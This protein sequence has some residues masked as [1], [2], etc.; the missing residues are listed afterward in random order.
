MQGEWTPISAGGIIN[1]AHSINTSQYNIKDNFRSFNVCLLV[2]F[3]SLKQTTTK[4]TKLH[5]NI[6]ILNIQNDKIDLI[7]V[8]TI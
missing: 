3:H 8:L 2:F 7:I 1:N 5:R 6:F 4:G